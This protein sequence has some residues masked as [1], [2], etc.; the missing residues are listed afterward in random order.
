M[1]TKK[2]I[3]IKIIN[4]KCTRCKK[5]L[6]ICDNFRINKKGQYNKMC[7]KCLENRK[8]CRDRNKCE[9]N[10]QKNRCKECGG[11][12]ICEHNRQK[13]HCKE[14]GG[15][16]ICEHNRE[17]HR[18]KKCKGSGICIHNRVK[19]RCKECSGSSI[20]KH[21]RIKYICKE[22]GGNGI[23]E[24][25]KHRRQC[26]ICKPLGHLKYIVR[27]RIHHALKAKK[28]KRTFEYLGCTIT[29]FKEHLEKSFT[30]GMTWENYGEWE[31]D[32]IIPI[33]YE[34]PTL[35]DV[36]ERLHWTNTQ[37]LWKEDNLKKGN[38]YIG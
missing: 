3:R 20:C 13:N 38:R 34:K 1:N 33:M 37:A 2:T 26:P 8:K 7:N 4:K 24:H 19:H 17:K 11:N 15:S 22:C 6:L 10:R 27:S 32:H 18:C 21:N 12:G 28:S 29:E 30:D 35:E 36:M 14:C 5:N 9:H 16:A 23:C 31:I 25:N